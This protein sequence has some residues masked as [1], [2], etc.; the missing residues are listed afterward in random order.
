MMYV[1]VFLNYFLCKVFLHFKIV[2]TKAEGYYCPFG[3]AAVKL[4]PVN[5][6]EPLLALMPTVFY[7]RQKASNLQQP[8]DY[9]NGFT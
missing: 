9:N 8:V 6:E 7:R 5:S 4:K 2:P 3:I 1:S